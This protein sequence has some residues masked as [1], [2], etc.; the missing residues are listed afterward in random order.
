MKTRIML[1]IVC[2]FILFL[3]AYAQVPKWKLD[4]G[5]QIKN[6]SFLQEGKFLFLTNYE[7]SWL[8]DAS[9]GAKVYELRVKNYE[10]KGVHQLVDDK[11]LIGTDDDLQCYDALT[12]QLIW[13]QAY[14]DV[15]QDDFTD[16]DWLGNALVVSYRANHIGI[17]LTTGK[18]LWRTKFKYNGDVSKKGGWNFK[19]LEKQNL[20]LVLMDDDKAGLFQF[21][22]GKQVFSGKDYEINGKVVEKSMR[23]FYAS[24]DQRFLIF[25]L[26]DA[27]AVV[28]AVEKIELKRIPMKYNTDFEPIIETPHGC[29][30]LGKE[31][32]VFVN[33]S[34]GAIAEVKANV[35]DFRTYE[36]MKAENKDIFFA[37]LADAMF[38]IDLTAGKVLWQ[39]KEKDPN[40]EGYAHRY[41]KM[42]E[43]NL[44]VTYSN[45]GSSGTPFCV[46]S[47]D[48]FT[49]V[50]K[51][52]TPTI[53][54]SK[55]YTPSFLRSVGKFIVGTLAGQK[56]SFGYE[57][58][59]FDYITEEYEGNL[60]FS[61]ISKAKMLNPETRDEGGE[62]V[63]IMDP[64]TG[65][66]LYKDYIEVTDYSYAL[67]QPK[68]MPLCS[69][70][71]DN[72]YLMLLGNEAIAVYDL[73][74]KKKMLFSKGTLKGL[75]AEAMIVDNIL[76]VKFGQ[77]KFDIKLDP[78]SSIFGYLG[79]KVDSRY[80]ED[81]Y[82]FA[83]YDINSGTLVWRTEAKVDPGFL[84][85]RF[86]L[87]NNYDPNTK[88]LYY[89][90]EENIYA[91]QMKP[92]GGKYDYIINLDKNGLGEMPF[93]KTYAIQEWPIGNVSVSSLTTGY[94]TGTL[95]TTTTTS[96]SIGGADYDKFIS[97]LE[98]ADAACQYRGFGFTIWGAVAK[99]CLR[100]V[101]S[102]KN[103][104]AIGKEAIALINAEDGKV[105]WKHPWEYNQD[106]VQYMSKI[107]NG[108]L[109][110]C[111]ERWLTCV[112]LATGE[113]LWKNK[114]AKRPILFNSPNEKYLYVIDEEEIHGYELEKQK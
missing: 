6:Y 16:L 99:K 107:L 101:Y 93:K 51:Y 34:T 20:I 114:E 66:I 10:K 36:V 88:R 8:F 21:S 19:K 5:E 1:L 113:T 44:I 74:A 54:L 91:L 56:H 73:A 11:F 87:K 79:M 59:G 37:G 67:P 12:G 97:N 112:D 70:I 106:N 78:P 14:K 26:D 38:A 39:S 58:I 52:K 108:K 40:F 18:E 9:T 110:Y 102:D 48:A 43:N 41:L 86:S 50:I 85:P 71:I 55:I 83:A 28:D 35:G 61:T 81:P 29:V 111:V 46:M 23:Y 82:G 15:S 98:Q 27:M 17:D 65:N 24:P 92:G 7:Y 84:T 3:A 49:G 25:L 62:G 57:S 64:K 80:D 109:V 30:V 31:N 42:D 4:I 94:G 47:I 95:T 96:T 33:D 45:G 68:D 69:P 104:F 103:I 13:K 75:P 72:N 63:V 53:F 105:I 89:A 60:V 90:D 76:Y 100:T 77:K 22:D 32:I 2:A